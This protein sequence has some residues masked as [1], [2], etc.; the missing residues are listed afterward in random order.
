M[1][2]VAFLGGVKVRE[3]SIFYGLALEIAVEMVKKGR[4][5]VTGGGGGI[6]KAANGGAYFAKGRSL[7]VGTSELNQISNGL[8]SESG[9]IELETMEARLKYLIDIADAFLF[10][11]GG[12]GTLQELFTVLVSIR[13]RKKRRVPVI[14]I[15]SQFWEGVYSLIKCEMIEEGLITREESNFITGILDKK[16]EILELMQCI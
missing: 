3:G 11:P 14:L 15:G 12:Y 5:V 13:I 8:F 9:Y 4:A 1:K 2:N 6:M 16:T 7:G 10:F